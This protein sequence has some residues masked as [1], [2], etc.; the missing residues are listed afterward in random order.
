MKIEH[1][2]IWVNDLEGMKEFY[3]KYFDATSGPKYLNPVKQFESYFIS[4]G[5]GPRLE[6]MR[7]PDVPVSLDD[8][9]R[10]SLGIIHFA[11][12]VGSTELVDEMAVRFKE[13]GFEVLD[14]PRITGD[15][16]YECVVL[17]PEQNR[18]EITT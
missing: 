14:G 4:F 5:N 10:Q 7:R 16:Y 17:D 12:S 3:C 1:L 11:V 15:G 6:L 9:Y 13:N 2:A 18:I 8:P